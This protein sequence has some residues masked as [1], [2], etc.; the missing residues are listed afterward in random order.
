MSYT[1]ISK[2]SKKDAEA[3]RKK[4]REY[5]RSYTLRKIDNDVKHKTE[6][7]EVKKVAVVRVV[8]A[9]VCPNCETLRE[10]A[11]EAADCC[12]SYK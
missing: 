3:R 2:L 12:D 6:K 8:T 11:Q 9:Y 1:P 10:T 4:Q 5:M 7:V